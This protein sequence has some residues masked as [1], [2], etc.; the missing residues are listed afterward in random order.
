M[1]AIRSGVRTE[2]HSSGTTSMM[3]LKLG[4]V[5]DTHLRVYG[6][7]NLRI[8]DAGIIPLV[9][10]AHLQALVYAIAEKAADIIKVDN[11]DLIAQGCGANSVFARTGPVASNISTNTSGAMRNSP[12]FSNFPQFLNLG[13]VHCSICSIQA[14]GHLSLLLHPEDCLTRRKS[15]C[16]VRDHRRRHPRVVRL[17][18]L[19]LRSWR[20]RARVLQL[21]RCR[22]PVHIP[23]LADQ[24]R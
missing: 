5:V 4:G 15:L 13:F 24:L 10:A 18:C 21:L 17:G 16:L 6:T 19:R 3:P 20:I 22:I 2:F 8:V 12:V 11:L 1:P 14:K 23:S 9:P 7:K